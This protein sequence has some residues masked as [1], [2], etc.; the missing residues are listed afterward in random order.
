MAIFGVQRV[1]EGLHTKHTS[2]QET[3][4]NRTETFFH[5][6]YCALNTAPQ[7]RAPGRVRLKIDRN[8]PLGGEPKRAE[9]A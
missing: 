9:A 3:A 4:G 7:G 5:T 6:L 1:E 8:T 2:N